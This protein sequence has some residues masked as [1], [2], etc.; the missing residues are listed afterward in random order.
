MEP[1]KA[2]IADG[3]D[4][5]PVALD[6]CDEC[7]AGRFLDQPSMVLVA[8][9]AF[10][11]EPL[12]AAGLER[13]RRRTCSRPRAANRSASTSPPPRGRRARALHLVR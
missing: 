3:D 11:D 12:V 5:R 7:V 6:A 4:G 10:D 13:A 1:A 8:V 9:S 2:A